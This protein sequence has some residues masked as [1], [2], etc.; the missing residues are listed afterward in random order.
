[1]SANFTPTQTAIA[2]LRPFRMWCQKV[3]PAIY[4]ESLSYYELL[5]KVVN[6]L[7]TNIDDIN[8]LN[9]NVNNIYDAYVLLQDYVNSF[10]DQNFPE[11]VS[12]KLDEMAEDGTLTDLITPYIDPIIEAQ[13]DAIEVMES[14]LDT[15]VSENGG[16]WQEVELYN[17][18]A[19]YQDQKVVLSADP[20][21]FDYVDIYYSASLADAPQ[22]TRFRGSDLLNTSGV[23]FGLVNATNVISGSKALRVFQCWLMHDTNAVNTHFHIEYNGNWYWSGAGSDTA[24]N[25]PITTEVTPVPNVECLIKVVGI[26]NVQDIEV[27][28]ARVTESGTTYP[29]L[30]QRLNAEFGDLQTRIAN[31]IPYEVKLAL[32]NIIQNV[33][34]KNATDYSTDKATI[35]AWATNVSVTSITAV[36]TQSGAVYNTDSLD[37]LRT[38]LVVTAY[39]DNG[40]SGTVNGYTLSGDLTY[41]DSVITVAYGGK[42][43]TITVSVSEVYIVTLESGNFNEQSAVGTAFNSCKGSTQQRMR[44]A[45]PLAIQVGDRLVTSADGLASGE[46][47]SMYL[48]YF[49]ANAQYT[50]VHSSDWEGSDFTVSQ[51][52]PYVGVS[53]SRRPTNVDKL[54][55]LTNITLKRIRSPQ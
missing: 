53:L 25:T 49:D 28:D 35:N 27:V 5:C 17:G 23:F 31:G 48:A 21:T 55:Q 37:V 12:A 36:Y 9:D 6:Y 52:Y 15:F 44:N 39:Y 14:R 40:T 18:T 19:H 24:V 13:N 42:T 20:S 11:L 10:F 46:V 26:K 1:M 34:F 45:S 7:N 47:V 54:T 32:N 51:N 2:D 43:T 3:L 38:D 16:H 30:G 50:G 33:A 4:D 22:I 41:G 8:T 29:T